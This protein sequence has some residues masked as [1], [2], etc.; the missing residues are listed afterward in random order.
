MES[1]T[2]VASTDT[3]Q[4]EVMA[5]VEGGPVDTLVIA[6]VGQDG[7]FL[8]TPLADAAALPAWR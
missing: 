8:T 3:G 6:D 4:T 7:A 5:A 2:A 1:E